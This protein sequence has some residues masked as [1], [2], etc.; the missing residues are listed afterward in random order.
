MANMSKNMNDK[1][2]RIKVV[3][4]LRCKHL[5]LIYCKSCVYYRCKNCNAKS[6]VRTPIKMWK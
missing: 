1:K 5:E 4:L 6:N 3:K 2:L